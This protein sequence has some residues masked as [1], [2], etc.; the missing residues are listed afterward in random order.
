[1]HPNKRG[2]GCKIQKA[3]HT[4]I[5]QKQVVVN[6]KRP[7]TWKPERRMATEGQVSLQEGDRKQAVTPVNEGNF[8]NREAPERRTSGHGRLHNKWSNEKSGEEKKDL[9]FSSLSYGPGAA[10]HLIHICHSMV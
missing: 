4:T 7:K 10:S 8:S 5:T 2:T 6:G 1:M 9:N 3:E